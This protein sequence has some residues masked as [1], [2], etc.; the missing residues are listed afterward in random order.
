[1]IPDFKTYIGESVWSDMHRRSNGIKV[2]KEDSIDYL[3]F[4]E[5]YKY[6]YQMY[7]PTE[8]NDNYTFDNY[9]S[10]NNDIC[11]QIPIENP[12]GHITQPYIFTFKYKNGQ[13]DIDVIRISSRL[14]DVYPDIQK[15]IGTNYHI[16]D[17]YEIK[18]KSGKITNTDIVY[19]LDK[20]FN[21]VE[22]PLFKKIA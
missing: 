6:L 9:T 15:V 20:L 13:D 5:F 3:N 17:L 10:Y 7:W 12:K 22:R 8:Y 16:T 21:M 19:L 4:N 1:M 11:I 2:K 14:I 18:P